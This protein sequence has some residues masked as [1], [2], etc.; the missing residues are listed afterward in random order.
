MSR[1]IFTVAPSAPGWELYEGQE[2]RFCFTLRED[3]LAAAE[4]LA[5][6]L[7]SHHGFATGVAVDM[8]GSESVL[9]AAHG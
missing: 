3:A 8:A 1:L 5:R 9:V 4:L 7:H 2:S 6:T